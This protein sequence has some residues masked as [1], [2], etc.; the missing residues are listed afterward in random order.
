MNIENYI[1]NKQNTKTEQ[2][3][4]NKKELWFGNKTLFIFEFKL[5]NYNYLSDNRYD[6]SYEEM[7]MSY[8]KF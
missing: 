2:F 4:I 5:N 8:L 3:N 7:M 1:L 6:Y